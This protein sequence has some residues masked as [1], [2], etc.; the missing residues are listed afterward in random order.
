M[1]E[2][3]WTFTYQARRNTQGAIDGVLVF[4]YE[5]TD[6]VSARKAIEASQKQFKTLSEAIPQ[7]VWTAAPNGQVDY[8]NSRWYAYT[9]QQAC[10]AMGE[11]WQEAMH[12]TDLPGLLQRWGEGLTTGQSCEAEAR[13]KGV[14]GSYRWF[15]IR[16]LPL[17]DQQG[18]IQQ[19]FGTNTDIH[20]RKLAEERLHRSEERLQKALSIQTVGVIFFDLEGRITD[21]NPAFCRMSGFVKEDFKS[22]RVRWDEVT[23]AEFMEGTLISRQE[24]LTRGENLPYEKQYIRADGSRWWGLFAGKRLNENECIEFVLDITESKRAEA[25]LRESEARFRLMADAVPQ[26]VWLTD[27]QGRVEFFNKQ[28]S[29]YTGAAYEPTTAAQV[30][31]SFVH[32]DEGPLTMEAFAQARQ[33]GSIFSVEHRIRS[34]EGNYRW[35]LV[36]AEPYRDPD[37]GEIL[38]WF[39][40]SI[41]IHDQKLARQALQESEERFRIMADAAPNIVWALHPDG[42]Q[43]YLN[44]FGLQYLGVTLQEALALNWIPFIHPED[45]AATSQAVSGAIEHQRPYRQEHRLRRHDGGYRWYLAQGAPSYYPSGELYGYVGSGI[46]I[47]DLKE[48]EQRLQLLSEELAAANEELRASNQELLQANECLSRVNADL[49]NFIYTASHDLKAPILNIEGLL[50]VLSRKVQAQSGQEE[51]LSHILTL[52]EN[53]VS[54][55]KE[56]INDLTDIA[57]IQKQLDVASEPVNLREMVEVTLLDLTELVQQAG[58]QIENHLEEH[59]TVVFPRKNLK[60]VVYNLLSNAVKYRNPDRALLIRVSCRTEGDYLVLNVQDN[61]LGMN[62]RDSDKIFGMFKRQHTHVEGTGIGLYIVKKMVENAGGRIEV[63]SQVGEGAAFIVYF[64]Q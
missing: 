5:V 14:D 6:Q 48:A 38:R 12:P 52:M 15:L 18:H 17:K 57:R 53:S 11:G 58:A 9:G 32:P 54:R 61:G 43:K 40:A 51:Q 60:S 21:A 13:I 41:D 50:K 4:A 42:T 2:I 37:T 31:A 16:A 28:W 25:A 1:E 45:L 64:K 22:G 44:K 35:F 55:F 10:Q 36:R 29:R 26:I 47:T 23:P 34:A 56:T 59:H 30:A 33:T 3:Y 19:W 8:F 49:D 62:T 24:L 39:G 7:L 63:E 46:D 20:D 27:P